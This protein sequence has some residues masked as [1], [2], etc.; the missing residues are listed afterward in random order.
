LV[1]RTKGKE[2]T[3]EERT[4]KKITKVEQRKSLTCKGAN[5]DEEKNFGYEE[6]DSDRI[7]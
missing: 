7:Y 5:R 1:L 2:N 3:C 6:P 4:S